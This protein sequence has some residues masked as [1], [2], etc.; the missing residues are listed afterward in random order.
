MR[1]AARGAWLGFARRP[2]CS[3]HSQEAAASMAPSGRAASA[4]SS[5][6][7][8][9]V[10]RL[11]APFFIG[12]PFVRGSFAGTDDAPD[13]LSFFA[14]GFGT[15]V[16]INCSSW[17]GSLLRSQYGR[18]SED[19]NSLSHV[20]TAGVGKRRRHC[21]DWHVASRRGLTA[22]APD[23]TEPLSTRQSGQM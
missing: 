6:E 19:E 22:I 17:G 16:A 12:L 3:F 15:G 13:R 20:A 9:R 14:C 21:P 4:F 11:E 23:R 7:C 5:A 1:V 2:T 18:N 8:A 10:N